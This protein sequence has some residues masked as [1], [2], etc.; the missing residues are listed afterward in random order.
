MRT[1]SRHYRKT[2]LALKFNNKDGA[3]VT[4]LRDKR[5]VKRISSALAWCDGSLFEDTVVRLPVGR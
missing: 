2:E 4:T 5:D 1:C 3:Y